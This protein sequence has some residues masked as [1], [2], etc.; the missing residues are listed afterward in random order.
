MKTFF[1]ISIFLLIVTYNS[2]GQVKQDLQNSYQFQKKNSYKTW[3]TFPD[4]QPK[5]KG[6]L[7]NKN[8]TSIVIRDGFG[9]FKAIDT[10]RLTYGE[11]INLPLEYSSIPIAQI[12]VL[13][14]RRKGNIA[15]GAFLGALTGFAI[16]GL[17][18]VIDG[19]DPPDTWFAYTAGEKALLLG[20]PMAVIGAGVGGALGSIR[21]TIPLN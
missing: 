12:D 19:D 15:R 9:N 5:M 7:F 6:F 13:K 4:G 17:I 16:G 18:A 8:D 10:S 11:L 2:F 14:A 20:V 21:V 3:I 1:Q